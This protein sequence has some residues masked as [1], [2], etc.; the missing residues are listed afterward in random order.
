M[1]TVIAEKPSVAK[2]IARILKATQKENGYYSGNGFA[3]SWAFGHLIQLALPNSYGIENFRKENLPII[4]SPFKLTIRQTREG[5]KYKND[6]V[7]SNQLKILD[8]LFKQSEYIIVA[9][10][11]GREGELIFRY[12]YNYLNCKT[13]F[14]R[15]WISSLTD[16]AIKDGLN[17][18]QDG[19]KYQLLY[20]SAKCRSEA[21]WL[22]GIN[23][24]QA[25][26]IIGKNIYSLGRV[27][28]PTLS[29]I[30]QRFLENKNFIPQNYWRIKVQTGKDHTSF[31]VYYPEKIFS[32]E[33]AQTLLSEIKNAG[34]LLV[35]DINQ[36]N[37][38]QEP[39]L[40]HDLTSLQKTANTRFSFSADMTLSIAQSL[41]EKKYISYP[42]TGS[43]YLPE[44]VFDEI[45]ER[46]NELKKHD[47]LCDYAQHLS[48]QK[49]NKR[50]VDDSKITDHH[51]LIITEIFPQLETLNTHEKAIYDLIAGRMLESF[52]NQCI[53]NITTIL[54]DAR[55]IPL[56]G[57]GT[58][59]KE[60]GWRGVFNSPEV[61]NDEEENANLPKI[62]NGDLLCI[63]KAECL[64]Q[65]TK[66]KPIHTEASLLSAMESAGQE[67]DNEEFKKAMKDSGLGTPATRAAII[68]TLVGR[69]YITKEKKKLLPTTK[70]LAVYDIVVDKDIANVKMTGEWENAL[71]M[72]ES[73][74]LT[75]SAFS[76]NIQ[77][78][79]RQITEELLA[80]KLDHVPS[81]SKET[82][83][84]PKCGDKII[85]YD[86]VAK[87][88]NSECG[89][90]VFRNIC[91]KSLSIDQ[92]KT[93]LEK[94]RLPEINGFMSRKTGKK[95]PGKL[96]L[97][98][99]WNVEFDFGNKI[100]NNR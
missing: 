2:E 35:T 62:D 79:T 33:K 7:A 95:F 32:I 55:S 45:P 53:K 37:I 75:E 70:G 31:V 25:L 76:G 96:I 77:Q 10:D 92:C 68:E 69:G 14:K 9:T 48:T 19:N 8:S 41:Y 46:I 4:P 18:L 57:K 65:K 11:A 58:I 5:K 89:L 21:D 61:E 59:T 56:I 66:P 3:V 6:P 71:S 47:Y 82:C 60:M 17:N 90:T 64:E 51:A 50:S 98:K 22:I 100:I 34:S 16:K 36:K 24:S 27:Q 29:M 72:I 1:V 44:D 83:L 23:A 67:L 12:I 52:S 39:P 63:E 88:Q 81:E 13:P 49:L 87:C 84:C 80:L 38:Y 93:L 30:C 85:I 40:L 99:E 15:L 28:T 97:T 91:G 74:K 73:G 42:R 94:K 54:L 43:Q 20:Q 86:K 78:Y 26:S